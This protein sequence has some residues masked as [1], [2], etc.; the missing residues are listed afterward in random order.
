MRDIIGRKT[1]KKF[2]KKVSVK[3]KKS[4]VDTKKYESYLVFVESNIGFFDIY[5]FPHV[6]R[7]FYIKKTGL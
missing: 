6:H 1:P 4:A 7:D 2:P 5:P 3:A